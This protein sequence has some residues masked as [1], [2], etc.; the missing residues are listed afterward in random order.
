[1]GFR[2]LLNVKAKDLIL[3]S[4]DSE[5]VLR[6]L[7]RRYY[8][9]YITFS[10]P[11]TY[12]AEYDGLYVEISPDE[13]VNVW[14][15]IR[16]PLADRGLHRSVAFDQAEPVLRQ[17]LTLARKYGADANRASGKGRDVDWDTIEDL[18]RRI[19]AEWT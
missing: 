16:Y 19:D 9:S 15:T 10:D 4:G 14:V 2:Q 12:R 8:M 1:M 5:D 7:A 18:Y 6:A 17:A 3:Q 11:I 13:G